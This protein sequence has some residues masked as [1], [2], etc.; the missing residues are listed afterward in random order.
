V[1]SQEALAEPDPGQ[2]GQNRR[3]RVCQSLDAEACPLEVHA[4]TAARVSLH[5]AAEHRMVAPEPRQRGHVQ[6]EVT[7]GAHHPIHLFERRPGA[8]V[9]ERIDDVEGRDDVED[10]VAEGQGRRR[11]LGGEAL[12]VP[13]RV[14]QAAVGEVDAERRTVT[15]QHAEVVSG[16]AA[17]VEE[18]QPLAAERA[19][20][21]VEQRR[22]EAAEP[23]EPEMF[24]LGARGHF[25][26]SIHVYN[27]RNKK[28]SGRSN[29]L[30]EK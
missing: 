11:S 21:L 12:A 2:Q 25:E 3:V 15:A 23:V 24:A 16:A 17:A 9:V 29:I 14:G 1:V 6:D 7:S 18:P 4:E 20:R 19:G 8:P 28:F 30:E 13:L 22:D 26:K 27:R 5:L 10:A